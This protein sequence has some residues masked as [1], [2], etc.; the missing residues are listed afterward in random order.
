M[1]HLLVAPATDQIRREIN[2]QIVRAL[3]ALEADARDVDVF[4]W[5][6]VARC[7]IIHVWQEYFQTNPTY[8][9]SRLDTQQK[10]G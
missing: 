2:L 8:P 9:P 4:R 3:A 10:V 6:D 5:E 7:G 1:S